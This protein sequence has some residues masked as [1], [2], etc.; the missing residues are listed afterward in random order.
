VSDDA[1]AKLV[2]TL[3]VLMAFTI[4]LASERRQSP[5]CNVNCPTDFS[6]SRK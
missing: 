3:I 4:W 5:A 6:A 2:V 1:L